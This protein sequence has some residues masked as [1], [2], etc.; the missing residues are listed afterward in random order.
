MKITPFSF[1]NEPMSFEEP[2]SVTCTISGDLP[3]DVIWTHNR[4]PIEPS[5][6]I[7]TEKRG[8]RIFTLMIESVKAKHAGNYSCIANNAAS[9]VE[10]TA[11]LIVNG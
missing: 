9:T 11:E 2:V 6:G 5:M 8:K 4:S 10:H 3:I 1:G 7:L